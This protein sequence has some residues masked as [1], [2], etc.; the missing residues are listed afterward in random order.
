MLTWRNGVWSRARP[1]ML[2]SDPSQLRLPI[3]GLTLPAP[4]ALPRNHRIHCNRNLRLDQIAA[5]GFD[6]D[7]T[8]A[9]Y[10][11][12]EMDRLSI[13]VTT[14]K[15]VERG[16]PAS[17]LQ[18]PYPV[19][20]PVRGLLVDR[21]RGNVLKMDRYRYV[22]VAYHGTR[23]LTSEERGELYKRKRVRPGDKRFHS[24]D[25]LF[26]L[27]EVTVFAAVIDALDSPV[28]RLDY[29]KVFD[30]VRACIDHAH[31]DGSIKDEIKRDL[32]RFI[33]RD[34]N[35]A[36]TLHKLRSSGKKLFLV[37]NSAIDYTDAVMNHLLGIDDEYG[38]WKRYFDVIVTSAAKPLFFEKPRPFVPVGGVDGA[39]PVTA[40]ERGVVYE[41]GSLAELERLVGLAGDRVLYVGDHIFGDVLRAKK[42]SAWR[43]M[44]IIQEM[45]A[46][47]AAMEHCAEDIEQIDVMQ[48][49]R[50]QLLETLAERQ[51]SLK[52]V[53]RELE[54]AS[55]VEEHRVAIEATRT[56][57]KRA[58]DRAR[59]QVKAIEAERARLQ[60]RV[61]VAFHP[62][63]GSCLKSGAELS[64]FGEQVERYACLYTDRVTNLLW[65]SAGHSFRSPRHR[66][67]HEETL[68]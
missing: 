19:H 61:D 40:L 15:L 6:M 53:I 55:L 54:D 31:Q 28:A 44:M 36:A 23:L 45:D 35:L 43:T 13:E 32:P 17:L 24:I 25:T 65:Y 63:W 52:N 7:Y 62:Y 50:D 51:V 1:D 30:D 21:Q 67:A 42:Q 60:A 4:G 11:Q 48:Q 38:S 3:R 68:G 34:P 29:A 41:Q 37:T 58:I 18:M 8:L 14:R 59:A 22:K 2:E 16:Y 47:L 26:A 39:P 9:I 49:R 64:S 10:N 27:C 46:E 12:A 56:R 57:L 20:F 5:V 33:P 66:M